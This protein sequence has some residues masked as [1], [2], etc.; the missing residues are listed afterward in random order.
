MSN[1]IIRCTE[2]GGTKCQSTNDYTYRC[3]YCGAT[4]TVKQEQSM[5]QSMA[6]SA[7]PQ[8]QVIVVQQPVYQQPTYQQPAYQQ[9]PVMRHNRDKT[10]AILLAFFLGG[11]GVQCFYLGQNFL[12]VLSILFCWTGIPA[13]FGLIQFIY[14]LCISKENFDRTFNM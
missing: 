7:T 10:T 12:G 5:A 8:P 9:Q 4:F 13:I 6:Q 3:L 1:E 2:C 14:L 11:I